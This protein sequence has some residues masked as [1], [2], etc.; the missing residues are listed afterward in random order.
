MNVFFSRPCLGI[1]IRNKNQNK[2]SDTFTRTR[3]C[4]RIIWIKNQ[5]T[6]K[7]RYK[8]LSTSFTHT[9]EPKEDPRMRNAR[10]C[11]R[12]RAH[13]VEFSRKK[14]EISE[15]EYKWLHTKLS[16]ERSAKLI[17]I[18]IRFGF[19]FAPSSCDLVRIIQFEFTICSLPHNKFSVGRIS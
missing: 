8:Y 6:T 14:K 4:V 1:E 17:V 10:R 2:I 12:D 15:G 9:P 13:T 19:P 5:T 18:H 16:P 7:I 3:F 11:C